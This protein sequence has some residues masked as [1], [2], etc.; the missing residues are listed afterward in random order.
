MLQMRAYLVAAFLGATG[1][2]TPV[3]S[4]CEQ[5]RT[6]ASDASGCRIQAFR[7]SIRLMLM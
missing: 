4:W 5:V 2:K 3:D 6:S 1:D 7:K